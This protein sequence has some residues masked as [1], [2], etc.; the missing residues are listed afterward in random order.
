MTPPPWVRS[1]GPAA[2]LHEAVTPWCVLYSHTER[3]DNGEFPIFGTYTPADGRLS[4]RGDTP[5]D[6]EQAIRDRVT[7]VWGEPASGSD[8]NPEGR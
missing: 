4:I 6:I 2:Q 8:A 3:A 1:E 5:A 7:A